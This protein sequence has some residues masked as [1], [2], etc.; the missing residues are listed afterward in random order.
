MRLLNDSNLAHLIA[1][2]ETRYMIK[3]GGTL[4]FLKATYYRSLSEREEAFS[5]PSIDIFG[6]CAYVKISLLFADIGF[7][8]L[9][10]KQNCGFASDNQQYKDCVPVTLG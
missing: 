10:G 8:Y 7:F 5:E 2:V 9:T 1:P 4:A 3:E 6:F